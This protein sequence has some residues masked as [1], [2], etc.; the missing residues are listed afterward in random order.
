MS[1]TGR[2]VK[3]VYGR[4]RRQAAGNRWQEGEEGGG[5]TDVH[6]CGNTPVEVPLRVHE[7]QALQHLVGPAAHA[8][9]GQ[10]ALPVLHHLVQ[11]AVLQRQYRR[12]RGG[13]AAQ[14]GS[15]GSPRSL[16]LRRRAAPQESPSHAT[17]PPPAHRR[18]PAT[19]PGYQLPHPPCAQKRR[20]ARLADHFP[21]LDDAGVVQLA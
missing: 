6:L 18:C 8:P 5:G 10:A 12:Y 21:Q 7:R 16:R 2:Q 3:Q 20:R 11:V 13:V 19:L 9:L 14:K 15:A 17:A 4:G 1:L